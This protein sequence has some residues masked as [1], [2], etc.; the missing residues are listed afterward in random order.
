[1]SVTLTKSPRA[2]DLLTAGFNRPS[3]I[4]KLDGRAG[5]Y[6]VGS[7]GSSY[8]PDGEQFVNLDRITGWG[9]YAGDGVQRSNHRSLLRDFPDT[10]VEVSLDFGYSTLALPIDAPIGER[11]LAV[12]R[13]LLDEYPLY[14]ESDHSELEME[15]MAEDW[16]SYAYS[17]ACRDLSQR[18]EDV[19]DWGLEADVLATSETMLEWVGDFY[20][21]GDMG[22]PYL[23]YATNI[24][25]PESERLHDYLWGRLLDVLGAVL[26]AEYVPPAEQDTLDIPNV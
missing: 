26:G 22:Y 11:L 7:Q 9:D 24:V 16:E 3:V 14:D 13:E 25:F 21:D 4:V 17:D 10:F 20:S 2:R 1:M 19:C 6:S 5:W 15:V 8:V 12:L 23:E 18:L